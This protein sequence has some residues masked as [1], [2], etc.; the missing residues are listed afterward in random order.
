MRR[1]NSRIKA[2]PFVKWAGGKRQLIGEL[3]R[4]LPQRYGVYYEPFVGGGALMFELEPKRGLVWDIN[5]ELI[6]AYQV[7]QTNVEG[8]IRELQRHVYEQ[9]YYYRVREADRSPD[10]LKWDAVRRASRL[11]YL[12][13]TC[14]NGLY[15]VNASGHF[16]VPFGRYEN[17]TIVDADN[18]R[19]CSRVLKHVQIFMGDF[20]EVAER[21]RA[22]DFVYLDPPYVPL[23]ATANFTAYSR[24]GFD[25]KMQERLRDLCVRLDRRGVY[26]M[27]SNSA[28]KLVKD[29]YRGFKVEIVR[30]SRA[31]NSKAEHRGK[32]EEVII[33]NY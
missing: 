11:I 18:L 15:R 8:L 20:E 23:T 4:R 21:T 10:F 30:A 17:P 27:L 7:V 1:A 16:N 13:R 3:M 31:V 9:R 24:E 29:M 33:R 26:W 19:A 2:V 14:Y 32:I 5:A 28:V 6:N 22:G 12:N 25:S